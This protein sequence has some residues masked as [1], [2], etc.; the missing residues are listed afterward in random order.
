MLSYMELHRLD[1]MIA[2]AAEALAGASPGG[3]QTLVLKLATH[4]PNEPALAICFAL[5]SA[6]AE[7]EDLLAEQDKAAK[8]TYRMAAL[9]A[10]DI[11]AVEAMG[12]QPAR[13]HHLL[14]FWRRAGP[15]YLNL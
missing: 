3:L 7:V 10:A 12:Q 15:G 5:T 2:T 14:H 13:A 9:V 1:Q 8:A 6:A 4:W 11:L